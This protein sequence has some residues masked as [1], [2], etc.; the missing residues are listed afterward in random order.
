[1]T[2]KELVAVSQVKINIAENG[3]IMPLASWPILL[4]AFGNCVIRAITAADENEIE[5]E[6]KRELVRE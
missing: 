6:L 1:M 3:L 2:L 4:D 5:V